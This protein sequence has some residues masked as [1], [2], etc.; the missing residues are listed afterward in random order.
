MRKY[1][2]NFRLEQ[3]GKNLGEG[4]IA[5]D[6]DLPIT[7]E[8]DLNQIGL[9]ITQVL[10]DKLPPGVNVRVKGWQK[11]EEPSIVLPNR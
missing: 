10:G 7:N 4:E 11:F 6:A 3:A 9:K 2:I 5:I 8:H 1:W